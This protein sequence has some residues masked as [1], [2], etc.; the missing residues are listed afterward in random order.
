MN[1][2]LL[3][4]NS[5]ISPGV[6][7]P[8]SSVDVDGETE[9]TANADLQE[10]SSQVPSYGELNTTLQT[11]VPDGEEASQGFEGTGV[12]LEKSPFPVKNDLFEGL[13]HIIMRD[14]PGN[15]Y[16]FDGETNVLWE[17]QIQG[18]FKR[19]IKGPIYLAMELPQNEKYKANLVIRGVARACLQLM[20]TMGHKD[21]HLSYGGSGEVPHI[22][23]PAFHSFDRVVVTPTG[24]TPPELGNHLPRLPSDVQRRKNFSRT[25]LFVDQTSTYTFSMK[26]RRFNPLLW[27]VVDVPIARSFT[28][29]RFTDAVRLALY[30]VLEEGGRPVKD[31]NGDVRS[32]AK[33]KHTKRNT[34]LWIHMSRKRH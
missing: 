22:G 16:D 23:A 33:K 13:V 28:V 17:I 34:F 6:E 25:E 14:L 18:K 7:S 4:S 11:P 15:T 30:E 21:T 19:P 2:D 12:D 3:H 32:M 31:P 1:S 29:S 27:K 5:R 20:K 9:T 24:E 8:P 10:D 26:N